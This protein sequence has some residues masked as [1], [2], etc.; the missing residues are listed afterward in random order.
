MVLQADEHSLMDF[1]FSPST[2][3]DS[4]GNSIL[5]QQLPPV[6][7]SPDAWAV[8]SVFNV[9]V[10]AAVA[11][12]P[13]TPVGVLH[14]ETPIILIRSRSYS[15][16]HD[17]ILL[18]TKVAVLELLQALASSSV[19]SPVLCVIGVS[20]GFGGGNVEYIVCRKVPSL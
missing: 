15:A 17:I 7:S 12:S 3:D 13:A 20:H 19:Q 1:N 11:I 14:T 9:V 5:H 16:A 2:H 10:A 6:G 8:R 4:P 18:P